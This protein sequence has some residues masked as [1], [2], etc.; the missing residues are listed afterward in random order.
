MATPDTTPTPTTDFTPP[1]PP[2]LSETKDE[3]QAKAEILGLGKRR[4]EAAQDYE[5]SVRTK[6]DELTRLL[7]VK[8]PDMPSP[9]DYPNPP[10]LKIRPFAEN[11]PGEHWSVTAKKAMMQLGLL[12]QGIGGL[13]TKYPQGALAAATGAYDGWAEGDKERGDR[14]FKD[15]GA[16]VEQMKNRYEEDREHIR[17]IWD[18]HH[19]DIES[20]KSALAVDLIKIGASEKVIQAMQENPERA[21]QWLNDRQHLA[22]E[23]WK[24]WN[25]LAAKWATQNYRQEMLQKGRDQLEETMRHN[26]AVEAGQA[27]TRADKREAKEAKEQKA[28]Q[29]M[30]KFDLGMQKLRILIPRLAA[31]GYIASENS[32]VSLLKAYA[33]R[34]AYPGDPD[35]QSFHQLQALMVGFD[36]GVFDDKGGKAQST[37]AA[38]LEFFNSPTT[39]AAGLAVTEQWQD[40]INQERASRGGAA[41]S[42]PVNVG[43]PQDI[44]PGGLG[45]T[46]GW[47]KMTVR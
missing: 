31:K 13:V 17:D 6:S 33:K 15:W 23:H 21:L 27:E 14:A 8:L 26:R 45:E 36:R 47:G 42:G 24:T 1:S 9:P 5:K 11:T 28:T 18:K 22:L 38:A 3:T 29:T 35:L 34:K 16:Q 37:F 40:F 2:D 30:G 4:V 43:R 12:A 7:G 19:G 25:E 41:P 44:S 39:D 46:A 10:S 32:P 20:L